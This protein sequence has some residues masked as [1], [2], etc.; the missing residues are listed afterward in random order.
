MVNIQN[1]KKKYLNF[2]LGYGKYEAVGSLT[3]GTMLVT[4]GA[5]VGYEAIEA[6]WTLSTAV[7][8]TACTFLNST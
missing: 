4:A 6:V 2:H 7:T 5:G 3:V 8:Q 1:L